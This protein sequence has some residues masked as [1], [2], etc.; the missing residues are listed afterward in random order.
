MRG[1][2]SGSFHSLPIGS[3]VETGGGPGP[4]YTFLL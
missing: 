1:R 2:W 3:F 4:K